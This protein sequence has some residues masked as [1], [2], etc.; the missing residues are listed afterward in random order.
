MVECAHSKPIINPKPDTE[1]YV[2][3]KGLTELRLEKYTNLRELEA[4]GNK[5]KEID[6][7]NNTQ[8]T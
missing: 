5:L 2:S 1:L 4:F 7:R 3:Y 6:L 8:L